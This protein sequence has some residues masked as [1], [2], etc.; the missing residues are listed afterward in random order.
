VD[1]CD[2]C[3]FA[4]DVTALRPLDRLLRDA[5]EPYRAVLDG[6]AADL[7]TRPA[8]GTWSA[9]EY[10]GHV[11]DVLLAQRERV[12]LA[13]VEDVPVF[14]PIHRDARAAIVRDGERP[15]SQVLAE[16]VFA[17]ELLADTFAVLDDAQLART[18]IYNYP[19]PQPRS[20]E[21]IGVHTLHEC[22]HHLLDI[23]RGNARVNSR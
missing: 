6:D 11:R 13:L 18:G 21:W 4:Y 9:L 14:T 23:E 22:H 16:L 17:A 5:V 19:T 20:V 8:P 7:R 2:E 12:L 10:A 1:T 3:G 15:P